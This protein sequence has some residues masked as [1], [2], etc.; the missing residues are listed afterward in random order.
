MK[1]VAFIGGQS[2]AAKTFVV[3]DLALSLATGMPFFGRVVEERVGVVIVVSEGQ[4]MMG[5]SRRGRPSYEVA[6]YL[7]AADRL[8]H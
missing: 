8:D 6:R 5:S 1:G 7:K 2:G 3:V 4:S